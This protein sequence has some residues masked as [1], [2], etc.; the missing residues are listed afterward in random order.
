MRRKTIEEILD[1][2]E[3]AANSNMLKQKQTM[4]LEVGEQMLEFDGENQ[5]VVYNLD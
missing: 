3:F 2:T 5:T 1:V 4:K